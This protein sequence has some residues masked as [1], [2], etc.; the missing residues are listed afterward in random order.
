MGR[1]GRL[2]R[3]GRVSAG[4][5]EQVGQRD[6]RAE[7]DQ[8]LA[9]VDQHPQQLGEQ[10]RRRPGIGHHHLEQ[11]LLLARCAAEEHAHRHHL[12]RRRVGL[13][14]GRGQAC[15]PGR[16]PVGR[17][18]QRRGLAASAEKEVA[19]TLAQPGALDRLQRAGEPEPAGGLLQDQQR[20]DLAHRQHVAEYRRGIWRGID[21]GGRARL[22]RRGRHPA[23]GGLAHGLLAARLEPHQRH[24][25]PPG[26][27]DQA[28]AHAATGSGRALRRT[29][30]P[31][32]RWRPRPAG[33]RRSGDGAAP[34]PPAAR[35]VPGRRARTA[36][37]AAPL[38]H[39]GDGEG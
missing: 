25:G 15:Q 27:V 10:A 1:G 35:C 33:S 20:S 16:I 14:R 5:D 32:S 24:Q 22:A 18:T 12:Q 2:S 9:A 37:A 23:C 13:A 26:E 28:A 17:A 36:P 3:G 19:V 4:L 6:R 21:R 34:R 38:R 7:P 11:R 31:R 8:G 30:R 39:P 29:G